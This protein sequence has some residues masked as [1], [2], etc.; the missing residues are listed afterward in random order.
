MKI[1]DMNWPQVEDYLK[2]NDLAVLP[3]GSTEQH[4]YLSLATDSI[5]SQRMAGEAAEPFGV[6][7]FPV[8]AYGVTPSFMAYPGTVSLRIST[9]LAVVRDILDSLKQHGFRRVLIVNGHGGN[10]PAANFIAEWMGD[11]PDVAVKFHNWWNAPR[12]LAKVQEIDPLAS[13]ASW[14][15]N[16]PWTRLAGVEQ[17]EKKKPLVDFARMRVKGPAAVRD[18]IGDG[19]FGGV[20][21]KSD[22]EMLAVWQAGLAETRDLIEGPWN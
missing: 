7:V 20:Y 2:T 12:T 18:L 5:L 15:E 3:L 4:A 10:Q 14:M 13:H 21:Q 22:E 19:N 1:S 16:F 8:V 6:P 9:Y 11:N 17:P